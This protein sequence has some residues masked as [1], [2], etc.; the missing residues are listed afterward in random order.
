MLDGALRSVTGG[1]S[2]VV[3]VLLAGDAG[4]GKTRLIDEFRSRARS[5]GVLVATGACIPMSGGGLPYGPFVGVLRD[6]VRQLDHETAAVLG[7][8]VRG[9]GLDLPGFGGPAGGVDEPPSPAAASTL[10]KTRLFSAL[11]TGFADLSERSPVLLVFE[12]LHWADSAT[13]ELLDFLIRNL[14]ESST[15]LV[16]TYRSDELGGRHVLRGPLIELGRHPGVVEI[17]LR[18]LDR[19]DTR[20]LL[21]TLLGEEPDDAF[22]AGVYARSEGNPFFVEELM[23]AL[24]STSISEELRQMILMRV[25]HMSGSAQRLVAVAAVIGVHSDQRL[26]EAVSDLGAE[27]F[28]LALAEVLDH[29]ILVVDPGTGGVRFR[30]TLLYE[31]ASGMVLRAERGRLH[32]RVATVLR[33][34]PE[35]RESGPGHGIAE[36]AAHWWAAEAWPEVLRTSVAAAEAASAVFAFAEALEQ[37]ERALVAWDRHGDAAASSGPDRGAI[38]EAAADAA[39]FAGHGHRAVELSTAAADAID[40]AVDP[41]RKAVWLTRLGRNAWSIGESQASLDALAEAMTFLPTA[42]PSVERARILAEQ[43]RGLTLLSRFGDAEP[44]CELAIETARAVG[45]RAEEGH[46]LNTLGIIRAYAGRHDEGIALLR[47]AQVIAEE[48]GDPDD[49]NRAYSNLC[50]VYFLAGRLQESATVTLDGVA[51]GEALGGVRFGAAALNSA[52]ALLRLGRLDEADAI[53]R[54]VE[55]VSGNCGLHREM[56]QAA[57]ALRRGEL[58]E[59][60]RY[61]VIVDE[62]SRG[63]DDVQF[64]GEFHMMRA[65][66]ALEEDRAVDAFEE[67]E[68]ALALAAA[69]DDTFYAPQMCMLGVQ[70]LADRLEAERATGAGDGAGRMRVVAAGLADRAEAT[71]GVKGS[72]G[73]VLPQPRA[74]ALMCRAEESRLRDPDP[75]LWDRAAA[76]WEE[77]G[78]PYLV[79]YCRWR[80]AEAQLKVRG[81]RRSAADNLSRAWRIATELGSDSLRRRTEQLARRARIELD[82]TGPTTG[83]SA[84]VRLGLTARE[85]EVLGCLAAGRTD[86]QIAEEL[87]ISKKTA[88]VHVSN[89]LRKLGAANRVEAGEIGQR[90]GIS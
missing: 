54:G 58:D 11:L 76:A 74:Y 55:S 44:C 31:A 72:G 35:L 9:L 25:D 65:E 57:I 4:I 12:D 40:P 26:L 60:G 39:Y 42:S 38:L 64:R 61:L 82:T 16:G 30:H 50:H 52:D 5:A 48:T 77:L 7:P 71:V 84:A 32:R 53:V 81:P 41:V 80:E 66:L 88:S 89:I 6:L 83:S 69:T 87:F 33:D 46:A 21:A 15:L 79:A 78:Q 1:E 51:R 85:T 18:G 34:R 20:A 63:L 67:I 14:Q 75:S 73:A 43:A 23:A 62:R 19:L 36:E 45:A 28:D 59:A 68:R 8:A 24:P 49:L 13:A 86:R 90:V 27:Q 70:A 37:L 29:Q 10:G 17:R 56:L 3:A 22:V 47:D 2:D